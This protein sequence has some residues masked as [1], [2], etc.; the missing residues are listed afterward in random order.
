MKNILCITGAK[1]IAGDEGQILEDAALTIEG[2]QI[3]TIGAVPENT[4]LINLAGKLLCP[5][6]IN[7]HTHLGDT[8]AKELGS[9]LPME[10]IV[11]PP[12]G[13][14]H[15]FLSQ[16]DPE[17]HIAMMRH[18]LREMLRNGVVACGDFREQGL[19]GTRMLQQAAS[20]LPIHVRIL[21]RPKEGQDIHRL[22]E[23]A[24]E[25]LEVSDGLGV[26]QITAYPEFFLHKLRKQYPKKIFAMHVDELPE[27]TAHS[28]QTTGRSEARRGVDCGMDFLIHLVHTPKD[29]LTYL[30][31]NRVSAVSCPR[32][33]AILGEGLPPLGAW[34][35]I[36]LAFGLGTDNIMLVP[37]DMMGEMQ[38][39]GR[40]A[41][42][43]ALSAAAMDPL[44]LFEAGTIHGARA[45]QLDDQLGSLAPGKEASFIV[46]DLN[47]PNLIYSNDLIASIVYRATPA[48]ISDVFVR[49]KK[50]SDWPI[51]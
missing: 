5:M 20:G 44:T 10:K 50:L 43:L 8:G 39:G 11:Q 9:G 12:D 16:V 45:L 48:D 13:L 30:I 40:M 32:S 51:Q 36:G 7:A 34:R 38:T 33:N 25:I 1:I 46:Y 3:K 4:P 19:P 15:R 24:E 41:C 2:D 14:K 42:G 28:L 37:P 29:D 27:Y 6:F 47:S 21:A 18:G 22:Q 35:E 49:G 23:E 26:R 31:Q 17:T